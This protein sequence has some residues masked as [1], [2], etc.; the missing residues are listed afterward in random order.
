M[1]FLVTF[2]SSFI[3]TLLSKRLA[4]NFKIVDNPKEKRSIPLL[5]GLAIFIGTLTGMR[6][7][8][9]DF[10]SGR[11]DLYGAL[12]GVFIIVL[13]GLLDDVRPLSP[14]LKLLGQILVSLFVV[15]LGIRFNLTG[16]I[17]F[18]TP[19][20]LFWLVGIT[21]AFNLLDN[22]D[23]LSAGIGTI[24]SI[25]FFL[26]ALINGQWLVSVV[27]LSIAGAC[28]GFLFFNFNPASIFMGDMGSMF[29][30]F[31]L[32]ILGTLFKFDH[33]SFLNIL[34]PS[35]ILGVPILDTTFVT[36]FRY[37]AGISIAQGGKDHWS[38]R[39]VSSGLSIKRAV[40]SLYLVSLL[41]GGVSLLLI[42]ASTGV[43]F[44]VLVALSC[45]AFLAGQRLNQLDGIYPS[46][47]P[48]RVAKGP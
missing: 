40:V 34:L 42:Q 27:S 33:N 3:F 7:F 46:S 5:G 2:V 32:A 21:N 39:L 4:T 35:L 48:R 47:P 8:A 12:I 18:D 6:F 15:L 37:R 9:I 30:G 10:F 19:M 16:S 25:F 41:L 26:I 36:I 1:I 13:I 38:H 28:L 43:I 22:M 44:I 17:W 31:I 23:G 11:T 20:T 29:L 45:S 24:A 14:G